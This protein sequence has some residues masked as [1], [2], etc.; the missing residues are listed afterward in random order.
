MKKHL[1]LCLLFIILNLI[2]LQAC[3][4]EA[5]ST[6]VTVA[7]D[8]VAGKFIAK[9]QPTISEQKKELPTISIEDL[10]KRKFA[11]NSKAWIFT[12]PTVENLS[13]VKLKK[14]DSIV[15]E[16]PQTIFSCLAGWVEFISRENNSYGCFDR[17][18]FMQL[19]SEQFKDKGISAKEGVALLGRFIEDDVACIILDVQFSDKSEDQD[20]KFSVVQFAELCVAAGIRPSAEDLTKQKNNLQ[21]GTCRDFTTAQF[22]KNGV[23]TCDAPQWAKEQYIAAARAVQNKTLTP[24]KVKGWFGK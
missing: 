15:R 18:N 19:M 8:Y 10:S 11:K 14:V 12:P 24:K 21:N 1:H 3:A 2:T 23:Y 7:K 17:S 22:P 4:M 20:K 6:A 16:K 9:E 5:I 13:A